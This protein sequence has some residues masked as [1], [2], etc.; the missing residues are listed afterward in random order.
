MFCYFYYCSLYSA[1]FLFQLLL[2]R[3]VISQWHLTWVIPSWRELR[4]GFLLHYLVHFW[5]QLLYSDW[6]LHVAVC[7]WWGGCNSQKR[8]AAS[9]LTQWQYVQ[10]ASAVLPSG[11]AV[12]DAEFQDLLSI[13][14][15]EAV[16]LKSSRQAGIFGSLLS[17]VLQDDTKRVCFLA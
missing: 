9:F 14:E 5:I 6:G 7:P 13:V 12:Q 10:G 8:L 4:T 11:F 17:S 1:F 3:S 16:Q 15:W 2:T